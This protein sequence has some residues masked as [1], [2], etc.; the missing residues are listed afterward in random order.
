MG[1]TRFVVNGTNT[2]WSNCL[3]VPAWAAKLMRIY[4]YSSKSAAKSESHTM[5]YA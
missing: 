1:R 4:L 3:V 5:L 2:A